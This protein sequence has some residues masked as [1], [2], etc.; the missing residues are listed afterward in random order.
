MFLTDSVCFPGIGSFTIIDG[1]QVSG[2]DAGNKYVLFFSNT[3]IRE[4]SAL[5]WRARPKSQLHLLSQGDLT[6]KWKVKSTLCL[7]LRQGL[8]ELI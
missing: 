6:F 5:S 8:S 3:C 7:G 1:N 2:E 4:G